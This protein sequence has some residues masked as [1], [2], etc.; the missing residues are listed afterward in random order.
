MPAGFSIGVSREDVNRGMSKEGSPAGAVQASCVQR[1]SSGRAVRVPSRSG[2]RP[3][4][5][6]SRSCLAVQW[7]AR[8]SETGAAR[9]SHARTLSPGKNTE[10]D[11]H[12]RG[13]RTF[14]SNTT[15]PFACNVQAMINSHAMRPHSLWK[16]EGQHTTTEAT[17]AD[18]HWSHLFQS[19]WA[20]LQSDGSSND[21]RSRSHTP[22][23]RE[24]KARRV[25]RRSEYLAGPALPHWE[26][27]SRRQ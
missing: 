19:E 24:G 5:R 20:D 12:T 23:L 22:S 13:D 2:E 4:Q 17:E 7:L 1:A 21:C 18:A 25:A 26:A 8:P 15:A 14:R 27:R 11:C 6:H 3:I 10:P 16:A 9:T